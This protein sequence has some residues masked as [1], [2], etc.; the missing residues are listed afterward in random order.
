MKKETVIFLAA[1]LAAGVL[2]GCSS[3][4][5]T[6]SDAAKPKSEK[7]A[8]ET[9]AAEVPEEVTE[10]EKEPVTIRFSW[11][12]GDSRNQATVEVI[13][14]FEKEYPWIT[15]EAEYGGNDGYHDKLATELAS[16]TAPDI[17]QIDPETMP[18]Y[19]KTGNYF[20]DFNE[21]DF[22]FS[23]Y[24]MASLTGSTITGYYDGRQYG[25]PTGV[26]GPCMLVNK[27]LADA[28]GIDLTK[29]FTWDDLIEWGKKVREYDSEAWLLSTNVSYLNNMVFNYY[30]KQLTGS[31]LF[32]A[33]TGELLADEENLTKAFSYIKSLFD[34]EVVEPVAAMVQYDGDN[35]QS[36]PGWIE[37]KYVCNITYISTA[38]VLMAANESVEYY[39]GEFPVM[40]NA[41]NQGWIVGCPQ[42]LAV[43]KASENINACILFLNYFYNNDT[44]LSTLSTQRSIPATA[45]AREVVE[46]DGNLNPLLVNAVDILT[47][48]TGIAN[49][50]I[51]SSAEA[52][53]IIS[54]AITEVA[55]GMST[56]EEAAGQ[57]ILQ[58]QELAE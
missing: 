39:A 51:G 21:T 14:Q 55:Y 41:K 37:G 52:K 25:I 28:A 33:E 49:D 32:D 43:S 16:G 1:V 22:D 35:L 13:E 44:A 30:M 12:G 19:V 40:E 53:Q 31:T 26:A 24:D 47:A 8:Q 17:M 45:H 2:S 20:V 10:E 15:V 23:A 42:I 4:N 58:Y 56:P 18:Q 3:Q 38:E 5:T 46:K 34:N 7:P 29:P 9:E 6:P 11:W 50:P 48:Y 57:V 36:E 27:N 54:D